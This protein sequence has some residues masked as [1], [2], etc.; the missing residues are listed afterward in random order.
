M[1]KYTPRLT[2]PSTTDKNYIHY[3]KGGYNYCIEIKNG[4]CLPNCFRK[5][6][7]FITDKG[8]KTLEEC[9][10]QDINVLNID[11]EWKPATVKYFGKNQLVRIKFSN[12]KEFYTTP[13]HRWFVVKKSRYK[14]N[15]YEKMI[16]TTT[17]GLK[18]SH[19]YH[20]PYVQRAYTDEIKY[21]DEGVR[22]GFIFGDG[23]LTGNYSS[24]AAICGN[25]KNFMLPFFKDAKLHYDSN[26]TIETNGMYSASYKQLPDIDTCSDE[27][28]MGFLMGYLASDGCVT[29]A[30]CRISCINK[31]VLIVIKDICARLKIRTFD[32]RSETRD[33]QIGEYFYKNHTL[34][35]LA[36]AVGCISPA[37]ILNPIHREKLFSKNRKDIK[38]CYPV[39]I[40]YTG[41]IDDV[42]CVVEP[43]T[44]TMVLDGNILTGQCVGY[45]WGRWREILGKKPNL[46]LRNAENWYGYT[47]DGY[48][49]GKT[50]KLGA[51]ICW[52]KGQV[53][54][55]GD[56]AGH[57]AIVEQ[58]KPNGTIVTSESCYGGARWRQKEYKAP[59][60]ILGSKYKFQGFIY[61]PIDYDVEE[62]KKTTTSSIA[63]TTSTNK[64]TIKKKATNYAK[65]KLSSLIGAYITTNNL[66]IRNGAGTNHTVMVTIPKGTK[67]KCYGYY[68]SVSNVKWLYI[69]FTYKGVIYDG[70][71]SSQYLKKQ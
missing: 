28:L 30:D 20:I 29:D 14:D 48:K 43:E 55:G 64:A 62:E 58:I 49:R 16:E 15:R 18:A 4:S 11:G 5:D 68:T 36:F 6:T 25:K 39:E 59:D 13:N 3:T 21:S 44:H 1:A 32:I 67:V 53:G 31:D 50:P 51:V 26:G 46:S 24:R 60:Y 9:V 17:D 35:H 34:Y 22:H 37:M 12:G 38:Y 66:N 69:E 10:G 45:S 65:S 23:S 7:K 70:F 27:Y 54:V 61:L 63:S 33:I 71:A 41:I 57:V 42:Y 47:E 40:E 8:V 52:S 19:N 2:A 56:G